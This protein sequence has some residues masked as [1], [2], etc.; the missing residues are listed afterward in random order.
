MPLPCGDDRNDL[1]DGRI[2]HMEIEA[3][4]DDPGDSRG[5]IAVQF[6]ADAVDVARRRGLDVP[7]MLLAA[8][9]PPGRLESPRARVSVGEYARLWAV[10]A[11]TMDDEFFGLDRHPMRRG[12]FR[13]MSQAAVDAQTLGQGL[14]RVIRFL[15]LVLDDVQGELKTAGGTA[16]LTLG[17][18]DAA[19]PLFA[20]GTYVTLVLGLVCWL[21]DRRIPLAALD[22]AHVAPAHAD[23]YRLLYGECVR[24]AA[25]ETRLVI[26]EALLDLPVVRRPADLADFLAGAPANFLVRYRNPHS[27]AARVRHELRRAEPAD[28]PSFERIAGRLG[29]APTT[30]RRRLAEEG[31]SF[32]GLKDALRRDQAIELLAR[33]DNHIHDIAY[34]LGFAEPSA[35]HR[36]F[37]KWTGAS[38][39]A[40]RA[41]GLD[42]RG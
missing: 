7:A 20:H 18:R 21:V 33:E 13:L 36:A 23:E 5:S 40:Y 19:V 2:C 39:G 34:A 4:P 3:E 42:G 26:D 32:Q 11:D 12:S 37:R 25:D 28:W 1:G 15:R 27:F 10:L 24:F 22:F 31:H 17:P 9:I 29:Q 8:G 41:S 30:L 38:P 35:F 16:T 14:R 6:V